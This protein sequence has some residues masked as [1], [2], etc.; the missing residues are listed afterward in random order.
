MHSADISILHVTGQP[1]IASVWL[2]HTFS[3]AIDQLTDPMKFA[4]IADRMPSVFELLNPGNLSLDPDLGEVV[5]TS[6]TFSRML[7]S[8]ASPT[9]GGGMDSSGYYRAF[10][11][12]I[13]TVI[14]PG[15]MGELVLRFACFLIT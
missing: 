5:E 10:V 6:Y 3:A 11:P 2:R 4:L 15:T 1:L 13:G 7:H 8:S 12:H 9:G 14:D